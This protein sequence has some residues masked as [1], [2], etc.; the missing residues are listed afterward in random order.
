MAYCEP[1]TFHCASEPDCYQQNQDPDQGITTEYCVCDK[2]RTLPFLT[3]SP[4]VVRTKSCEYT[5]LPP[6]DTKR[7]V[8]ATWSPPVPS[9]AQPPI[10]ARAPIITPTPTLA[11]RDLTIT[12]DLGPPTTNMKKC[13]VCTRVVNN[14]DSC[15]SIPGCVVPTGAVT[16][17]AGPSSVHVG[18]VTG[19]QLYTSISNALEGLCPTPTNNARTECKA[20]GAVAVKKVPYKSGGFLARDGEL[21]IKVGASQYNDTQIRGALI[22]TA[23]A[24]AQHAATGKNCYEAEYEVEQYKRRAVRRHWWDPRRVLD[25]ADIPHALP[26]QATWCNTVGFYG[27]HYY[28]PW[29]KLQ[30][31]PGAT[32]YLDIE[33]GFH[34]GGTGGDFDCAVLQ[35]AADALM[36]VAPEFAVGEIGL[37]EII[38]VVCNWVTGGHAL[39]SR[40]GPFYPAHRFTVVPVQYGTV[41]KALIWLGR[42]GI[43]TYRTQKRTTGSENSSTID[44]FLEDS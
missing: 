18:T 22:K 41:I 38:K 1:P 6:K 39:L 23:A 34:H 9:Q 44:F 26:S 3:I 25:R 43:T 27:P 24:A 30:A 15:S 10:T 31:Q 13:Q 19:T 21:Q 37:G 20:E 12:K 16:I 8:A 28:N 32:A 35:G 29:W 2:T 40:S 14:E 5:S 33:Y 4:T 36:F 17:E 42:S 11:G 7:D